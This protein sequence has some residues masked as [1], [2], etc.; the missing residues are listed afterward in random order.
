MTIEQTR[1][2][3]LTKIQDRWN[4]FEKENTE[5]FDAWVA[6]VKF[7]TTI[8]LGLSLGLI[9]IGEYLDWDTKSDHLYHDKHKALNLETDKEE[10]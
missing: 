2:R 3:M 7:K 8:E 4:D 9:S 6:F 5:L 1:E 10:N